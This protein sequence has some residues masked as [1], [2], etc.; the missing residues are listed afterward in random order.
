MRTFGMD[1]L[2]D[3]NCNYDYKIDN[4]IQKYYEKI[5][6]FCD[7]FVRDCREHDIEINSADGW[8]IKQILSSLSAKRF[9]L[10]YEELAI[11]KLKNN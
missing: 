2:T 10:Y 11:K 5:D 4:I 6:E 7:S 1:S 3:K 8:L 9:A